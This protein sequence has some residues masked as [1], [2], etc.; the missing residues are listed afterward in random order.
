MTLAELQSNPDLLAQ[1]R[2]E[3]ARPFM[4]NVI[5][6]M[7]QEECLRPL[8]SAGTPTSEAASYLHGLNVGAWRAFDVLTNADK[9]G[10]E[11][12]QEPSMSYGRAEAVDAETSR[13]EGSAK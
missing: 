2:K 3:I 1:Y 10:A 8:T 13:R 4:R 7:L 9:I 5:V 11:K 6:P 12:T